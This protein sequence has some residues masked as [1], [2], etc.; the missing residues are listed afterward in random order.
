MTAPFFELKN[1]SKYFARVVA[2]KNVS[3]SVDRGEVL[4]LLGENGAGKSTVMKILYG[5][6]KSDEGHIYK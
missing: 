1:V 3:F 2:N 4:A 5:L 6:Y